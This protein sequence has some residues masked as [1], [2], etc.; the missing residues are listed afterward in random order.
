MAVIYGAIAARFKPRLNAFNLGPGQWLRIRSNKALCWN[1]GYPNG[2]TMTSVSGKTKNGFS[3]EG[4]YEQASSD[5]V[6]WTA[7]YRRGGHFYGMRHGRIN[8][9]MG[10]SIA[11]VDDAVKDDIELTWVGAT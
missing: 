10:V 11:E 3:Y 4:N 5:R 7:T 9:L 8:E 1:G 2:A 6:T